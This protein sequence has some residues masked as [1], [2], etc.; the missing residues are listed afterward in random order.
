MVYLLHGVFLALDA[1]S[2]LGIGC[3][4]LHYLSHI[5]LELLNLLEVLVVY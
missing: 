1:R 4:L 3:E 2:G 5:L